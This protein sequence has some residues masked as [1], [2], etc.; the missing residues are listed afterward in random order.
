MREMAGICCD[1]VNEACSRAA[2][3]PSS[4]VAR[5][6]RM[7]IRRIKFVGGAS[8]TA[9]PTAAD[10]TGQKRRKV[11]DRNSNDCCNASENCLA[12][13][14]E[15]G[16]EAG[17][18]LNDN[19]KL[20]PI[21]SH[22]NE[23]LPSSLGPELLNDPPKYGVTSVCGRRREME[24]AVAVHPSFHV[25]HREISS[26]FHYFAVY[27]GHGCSHVCNG[28]RLATVENLKTR[29]TNST[30]MPLASFLCVCCIGCNEVQGEIA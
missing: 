23:T 27:D 8:L 6:R 9:P 7:D 13:K 2:C 30:L 17:D 21:P 29:H 4:R 1:V 15:G 22:L 25:Q 19:N 18:I 24:D 20:T 3:E 11:E 14:S 26:G 16:S 10:I 5:R 28:S 12:D